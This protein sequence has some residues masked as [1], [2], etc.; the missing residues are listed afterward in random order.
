MRFFFVVAAFAFV[1]AGFAFVAVL[2]FALAACAVAIGL[3]DDVVLLLAGLVAAAWAAVDLLLGAGTVWLL[4]PRVERV[5]GARR[6]GSTT[7]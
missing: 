6:M 7:P 4:R 3:R 5:P 1:A 2:P